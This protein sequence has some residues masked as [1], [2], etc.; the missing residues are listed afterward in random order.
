MR[1]VLATISFFAFLSVVLNAQWV[2]HGAWASI[3]IS[4][5]IIRNTVTSAD[6]AAR[7]DRDFTRVSSTFI[8]AEIDREVAKGLNLNLSFRGGACMKNEY[9]W[10]PQRRIATNAKYKKGLGKKASISVRLQY[11]SGHKGVRTPG[12]GLDF[13]RAARTKATFYYRAAK[14]Y[15][16]SLSGE[17]FFR[18]LYD[19]YEFSDVRGR[20]SLRKKL[21]K[22]KYLTIGYQLEFPRGGPDP[23]VEQVIV[24]NFSAQMKRRKSKK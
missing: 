11:Q 14:S 15:R 3:S 4:K 13:S 16:L 9:Q 10:E 12:E 2:D 6:F 1:K 17:A 24:C 5:K 8:N 22:R 23:W 19:I 20:I 7:F 18:P 21:S